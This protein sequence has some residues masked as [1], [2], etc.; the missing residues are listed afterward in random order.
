MSNHR[1]SHKQ[2]FG[3]YRD[4]TVIQKCIKYAHWT[5]P[6]LMADLSLQLD[7]TQHIVERDYQEVGA[8]LVNNLAPKLASMLFPSSR[9]FYKI[10]ASD[11]LIEAATAKGM[12]KIELTSHFAQLE[13]KSCQRVFLNASY[14]QVIQAL[15]HLIVTGNTLLY[16]NSASG[17]FVTYGVQSYSTRRDG[18]GTLLDTVLREYTHIEA[19]D[20]TVQTALRMANRSRYQRAE[21]SPPVELYT[22]I[23]RKQG[24]SGT[25][26]YEV[27]QEADEIP[28][29]TT[30]LYPEVLCPWVVIT[31]NQIA[32][33]NYG[34]G[35]VEDFAGGF[36]KLSDGSHAAALYGIELM[37]VVNLVAPGLGADID[38][39]ANAESGEYVQG[40]PGAVSAYENG[41]ATKLAVVR[42]ELENV[43]TNLSRAF[44]YKGNTR[45]A[46]RVTAFEI[47]QDALEADNV[48]GGAYSTLAAGM[49]VPLAHI[50]LTEVKSDMLEGIVTNTV[51]LNIV[52][53]IPALGRATDVQNLI[54]AAQDCIAIIPNL[55]QVDRR[56]D[57]GKIMDMIMAGSS[58]DTSL[59]YKSEDQLASEQKAAL[60]QQQGEQQM[61]NAAS[62]ADA[63]ETLQSIQ[64]PN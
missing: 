32:G 24:A 38:E 41:D 59:I 33:E 13:Q 11:T 29:G 34:R 3:K 12:T 63:T 4:D 6:Q 58:V 48:L 56:I 10:D 43:I 64:G 14:A 23:Q 60:A 40:Q 46:E 30:G 36:A 2:R 39:L 31:W 20:P 61:M 47:K 21:D 35:L 18:Q 27:T 7:G 9:P 17:K 53:G 1:M 42:Q 54:L 49:Q 16:R 25:V 51:E 28:V 19:L 45:E 22:R 57:G 26:Y 8:L 50:C 55:M 37:K 62:A 44:M 5:L 52:A 15:R